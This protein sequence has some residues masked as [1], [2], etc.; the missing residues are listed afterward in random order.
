MAGIYVLFKSVYPTDSN[1]VV[2]NA[3][4]WGAEPVA[5]QFS[6]GAKATIGCNSWSEY[7]EFRFL[8]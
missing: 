3:S 2:A 4:T 1:T 5:L 8:I 7:C 6:N